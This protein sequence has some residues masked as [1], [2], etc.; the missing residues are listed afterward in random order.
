MAYTVDLGSDTFY[1]TKLDLDLTLHTSVEILGPAGATGLRSAENLNN[2][3][4]SGTIWVDQLPELRL[5]IHVSTESDFSRSLSV[6]TSQMGDALCNSQCWL[7][8]GLG[9]LFK[10]CDHWTEKT[11]TTF[12]LSFGLRRRPTGSVTAETSKRPALVKSLANAVPPL[13]TPAFHISALDISMIYSRRYQPLQ[14]ISPSIAPGN[15]GVMPRLESPY[16]VDEVVGYSQGSS[17]PASILLAND[18]CQVSEFVSLFNIGFST[19]V[20]DN[21]P[22]IYKYPMP[23]KS[24]L[25]SLSRIAPSVFSL[26]YREAMNERSQ[27]IPLIAKSMCSILKSTRNKSLQDKA[28]ALEVSQRHRLEG[29]STVPDVMDL[30]TIIMTSLWCIAQKRLYKP[31]ASQKLSPLWP[32]PRPCNVSPLQGD[33]ATKEYI[34][35]NIQFH[36]DWDIDETET[37]DFYLGTNGD[38]ES[39]RPDEISSLLSHGENTSVYSDIVESQNSQFDCLEYSHTTPNSSWETDRGRQCVSAGTS[40][41]VDPPSDEMLAWDQF[42]GYV[43]SCI[44]SVI[45][46]EGPYGIESDDML[47][48]QL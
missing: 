4:Y 27:L 26:R 1:S 36:D 7:E 14:Y 40:L 44:S 3:L 21:P 28:A 10:S 17:A 34:E 12:C 18:T 25:R 15:S 20:R 30:K 32:T 19:L 8:L 42:D 47:C 29:L 41:Y 45:E 9:I 37:S 2:A 38:I 39:Y 11:I 5:N 48:N 22:R 13:Y 16:R 6:F 31:E 43:S 23:K 35:E 24:K 46:V 33:N